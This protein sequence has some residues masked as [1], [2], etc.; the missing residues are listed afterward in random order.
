MSRTRHT[1]EQKARIVGEFENYQGSTVDF[2][3]QRG[4]SSQ[5]FTN[6]RRRAE[7]SGASKDEPPRIPRIR[8]RSPTP[9]TRGIR[10]ARRT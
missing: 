6:W 8:T 7:T 9:P 4:I 5:T 1:D 10:P 2:C 3:R